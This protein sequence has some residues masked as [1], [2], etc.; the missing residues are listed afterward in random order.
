MIYQGDV[1]W[2]AAGV[3][4]CSAYVP[5]SLWKDG[6]SLLWKELEG[7]PQNLHHF[8]PFL[9]LPPIFLFPPTICSST[10]GFH[11]IQKRIAEYNGSQ[12][13]Y[14]T[15]GFVMNMYRYESS[16]FPFSLLFPLTPPFSL[17]PLPPFPPPFYLHP[18]SPLPSPQPLQ[19]S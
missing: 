13:G 8:R 12:C 14:C 7:K 9:N 16:P 18:P 5:C 1:N 17:P 2:K 15:P 4:F 11:P 10:T 3:L 6:A 19:L